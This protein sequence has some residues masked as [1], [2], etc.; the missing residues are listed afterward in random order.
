MALSK[1]IWPIEDEA[2]SNAFDYFQSSQYKTLSKGGAIDA[3]KKNTAITAQ[4]AL[5][6]NSLY[7]SSTF[8][9]LLESK[10][11]SNQY[12]FNG[13][14]E[15]LRSQI[16]NLANQKNRR[17][18]LY[19]STEYSVFDRE[20]KSLSYWKINKKTGELYGMLPDGT[21]GGSTPIPIDP[22]LED[23]A[24]I[25][26]NI[27]AILEKIVHIASAGSAAMFANPLAGVSLAVVA[28]YGVTLAKLYGIVSQALVAM[29]TTGMDD[30]VKKELQ[31]LAC[32]VYKEVVFA[33][34][35]NAGATFA[36]LEQLISLMSPDTKS[37]FSCT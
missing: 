19:N 6:E 5:R 15:E 3:F 4:L 23:G 2:G 21:G 8:N 12:L 32:E 33:I 36:G 37:P 17:G 16:R 10:L 30:R 31:I 26:L 11:I 7:K 29:D 28:K 35:G 18:L 14:D 34:F 13:A 24:S 1:T 27:V 25:L 9:N 22:S 20:L